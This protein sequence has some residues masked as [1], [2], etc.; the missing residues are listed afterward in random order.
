MLLHLD[1]DLETRRCR[2]LAACISLA[3]DGTP[4]RVTGEVSELIFRG[5]FKHHE[6]EIGSVASHDGGLR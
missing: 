1:F 5:D 6:G 3:I 2:S 4:M